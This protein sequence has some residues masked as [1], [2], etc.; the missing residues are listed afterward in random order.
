MNIQDQLKVISDSV[1]YNLHYAP[2]YPKEDATTLEREFLRMLDALGKVAS[3]TDSE[4]M[5]SWLAYSSRD[6]ESAL[7]CY[8]NG[9]E[10]RGRDT[11]DTVNRYL[12]NAI[13]GKSNAPDFLIGP[14]GSISQA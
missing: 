1:M 3:R 8:K 11:L 9:D 7:G 10:V 4:S 6:L 2:C 13:E 14:S 5:T 12:Q